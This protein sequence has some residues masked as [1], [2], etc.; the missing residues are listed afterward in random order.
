MLTDFQKFTD[1]QCVLLLQHG[2]RLGDNRVHPKLAAACL[3]EQS[4]TLNKF[5]ASIPLR[6]WAEEGRTINLLH[7]SPKKSQGVKSDDRGGH[8]SKT[9]SS[10]SVRLIHLSGRFSFKYARTESF[11]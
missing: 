10:F 9:L 1:F 6:L 8:F 3:L 2:K 7:S 4:L 11:Q 5:S